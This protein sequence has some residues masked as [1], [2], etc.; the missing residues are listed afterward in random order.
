MNG[1]CLYVLKYEFNEN[2]ENGEGKGK[3]KVKVKVKVKEVPL[4]AWSGPE[5]SRKL[6]FPDFMTTAQDCRKLSASRTG[7]I[8]P[9]D[10]HLQK[11]IG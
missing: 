9:H 3:G 7:R 5:G 2:I 10:I 6:I 8:Y 4:R 1:I 11:I